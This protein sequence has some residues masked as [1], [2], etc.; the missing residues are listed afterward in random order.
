MLNK[1]NIKKRFVHSIILIL[2]CSLVKAE[3]SEVASP[4]TKR[5]K[6]TCKDEGKRFRSWAWF[7]GQLDPKKLNAEVPAFQQTNIKMKDGRIIRGV[8]SKGA[9]SNKNAVLIIGGNGWSSKSMV[10]DVLP[11]FTTFN[12]DIY[13]FDFR[14][15][16]MST[17]G[18]AT[19]HA[20]IEDYRDIAEWLMN[21]GHERLYLYAF[22]FG[23]VVALASFPELSPFER[24]VIDSAPSRASDF[25]FRC[26]PS[27]ESVDFLPKD[28][29]KLIVMHGTSD[30][31]IPRA[32]VTELIETSIQC[33]ATVDIEVNRGHPFQFE[34]SSSRKRRTLTI[35]KHFGIDRK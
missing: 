34:W 27:Y 5:E 30:W 6:Y 12:T 2:L 26:T 25:G 13:Y 1:I 14:G 8:L 22:S 23:G 21:E 7:A 15:Y 17:P 28:C 11:I 16:G 3:A 33:G 24:V 32:K 31:V 19:M 20:F 29:T 4:P 10:D 9:R 18:N 35:M